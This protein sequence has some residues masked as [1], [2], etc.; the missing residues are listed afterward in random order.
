MK[1]R[2]GKKVLIFLGL[3][4]REIPD[5]T[6]ITSSFSEPFW[7]ASLCWWTFFGLFSRALC[8]SFS[9][10]S[11]LDIRFFYICLILFSFAFLSPFS[12]YF[13]VLSTRFFSIRLTPF[14]SCFLWP[15]YLSFQPFSLKT[16]SPRSWI[17]TI[18]WGWQSF[19]S[20]GIVTLR[21]D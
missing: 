10:C 5:E 1:R 19:S 13:S 2:L 11:S 3:S 18:S 20:T 8:I 9:R 16:L 21:V 6:R 17:I 14:I 12:T 15:L 4:M 7:F